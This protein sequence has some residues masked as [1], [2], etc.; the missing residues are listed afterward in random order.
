MKLQKNMSIIAGSISVIALSI[1][2]IYN[3]CCDSEYIS[4][5][6]M[7]VFSSAIL[8]CATSIL[9]YFNERNKAIYS[10]YEG[11][12]TFKQT[13]TKLIRPGNQIDFNLMKD[14]FSIIIESYKKDIYYPVCALNN[15]MLKNTK[16]NQL[17]LNIWEQSRHLYL[18]V[19]DDNEKLH[20]YLL[21][22][23]TLDE[24]KQYKF[25]VVSNESVEYMTKL[26][27]AQE[28]LAH[29]MN[30]YNLKNRREQDEAE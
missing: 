19:L 18:L 5:L 25:Q 21:N 22:D 14:I 8:V 26:N 6:F 29:Y 7:G 11:C 16:L 13:F 12:T 9:T 15:S 27:D 28:E 3:C 4:N 30:Y 17:V 2:I 24:L 20:S 10:L 23:I 1:S